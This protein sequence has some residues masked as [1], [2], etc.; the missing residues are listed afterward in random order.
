[1]GEQRRHLGV[2]VAIAVDVRRSV[3]G[4]RFADGEASASQGGGDVRGRDPA[5]LGT[6]G[7]APVEERLGL[8]NPHLADPTIEMMRSN[9]AALNQTE[10]NIEKTLSRSRTSTAPAPTSAS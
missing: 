4:R 2:L 1:V 8:G 6:V 7:Q 5:H 9:S 10:R 3:I